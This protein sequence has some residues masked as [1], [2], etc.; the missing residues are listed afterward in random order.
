VTII[1]DASA[2]LG[3]FFDEERTPANREM[4]DE[5]AEVGAFVPSLWPLEVANAL[6]VGIRRGRIDRAFRD[7][8]LRDLSALPIVVDTETASVAWTSSLKLADLCGLT[9]YD[10]TYLELALRRGGRLATIDKRLSRRGDRQRRRLARRL[11]G[12][13]ASILPPCP[14]VTRVVG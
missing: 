14:R 8:S 3:A 1:L 9:V 4:F 6:Q 7:A 5:I 11:A 13:P 12:R 10:A 2:T